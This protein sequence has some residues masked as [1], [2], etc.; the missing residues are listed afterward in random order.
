MKRFIYSL[1]ILSFS[2]SESSG[3]AATMGLDK[4]TANG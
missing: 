4:G 2:L 1:C 3:V